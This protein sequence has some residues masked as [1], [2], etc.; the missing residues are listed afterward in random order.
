MLQRLQDNLKLRQNTDAELECLIL[1]TKLEL[2]DRQDAVAL[3]TALRAR[4]VSAHSE[5]LELQLSAREVF[6]RAAEASRRWAQ[7]DRLISS[8]LLRAS[9]SGCVACQLKI[10]VLQCELKAQAGRLEGSVCFQ[11]L[12]RSAESSGFRRIAESA[13]SKLAAWPRVTRF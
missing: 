2:L 1:Q 11:N 8:A 12:Q 7:A 9:Q 5:R 13:A 10:Q 4:T 3:K 6:A